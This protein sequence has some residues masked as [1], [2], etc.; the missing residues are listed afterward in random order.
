MKP[1]EVNALEGKD[2]SFQF[3]DTKLPF[4]AE[5]FLLS[6]SLPNFH[7]HA[8]TAYEFRRDQPKCRARDLRDG[9]SEIF[10]GVPIESGTPVFLLH[11]HNVMRRSQRI[12]DILYLCEGG[13]CSSCSVFQRSLPHMLGSRGRSP[14]Q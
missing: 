4:V 1:T 7:F 2:V 13:H 12:Q 5:A 6:F 14:V 8:T 9:V 11:A 10:G 3:R